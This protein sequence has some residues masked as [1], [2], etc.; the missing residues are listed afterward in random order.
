M[1]RKFS[2]IVLWSLVLFSQ[3]SDFLA[4]NIDPNNPTEVDVNLLI[5][6]AQLHIAG[7]VNGD[8]GIVGG[9]WSQ[10]WTQSHVASQYREEDRYALRN[11]DY[12]T[13]WADLYSDALIDLAVVRKKSAE[14]NNWAAYL[15]ATSLMAYTYQIVVDFYDQIPFQEAL[16]SDEGI[17][18]P[19][20]DDGVQVYDGLINMLDE[21]L[22]KDIYAPTSL[23]IGTDFVFG[24]LSKSNQ[25]DAWVRFA[26]TLKL[27]IYLR[28]TKVRPQ[29]AKAG[30]ENLLSSKTSFLATPA[31]ISVFIDE[32]NKSYPLYETDRRQLNVRS[33]LR[34]SHTFLSFLQENS[35]PRLNIYFTPG[36]NGHFGLLQGDFN[37]LTS[38]IAPAAPSVANLSPTSSFY[39]FTLDDIY[40]MLSEAH[41][42]FGDSREAQNYYRLAVT[43]AFSRVGADLQD[44]LE[45]GGA[46]AYPDANFTERL[47]AIMTQK[48]VAAVERGYESFFDQNRT[49]IPA[50]SPVRGDDPAYVPG[51]LTYSIT[52]STGSLFPKRLIFPDITRRN[53]PNTPA[54]VP[55]TVPVWWAK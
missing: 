14:A 42:R 17:E 37:A 36:S 41:L 49:G 7:I 25:I 19:K 38:V 23:A 28:Q 43:G 9:I 1:Q 35:D 2:W 47:H 16:R 39:F 22:N 33:N 48:W 55:L 13:A 52:G 30:I 21:A 20:F 53:N 32:A 54:E 45:P 10:H 18:A 29:V 46:Y 3:C 6:S 40:F 31:K 8:F 27:K 12:N 15:Q 34:A 11:T 4:V 5:P 50:I 51:Q 24:H 26:N 44:F